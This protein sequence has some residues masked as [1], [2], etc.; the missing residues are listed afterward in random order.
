MQIIIW[1]HVFAVFVSW[2]ILII[3]FKSL[4]LACEMLMNVTLSLLLE[5]DCEKEGEMFLWN[6]TRLW[7]ILYEVQVLQLMH[8]GDQMFIFSLSYTKCVTDIHQYL[9]CFFFS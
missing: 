1:H 8:S 9:L 5:F 7:I 2:Y 6:R 4:Q 3:L